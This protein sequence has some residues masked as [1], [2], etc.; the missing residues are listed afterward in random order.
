MTRCAFAVLCTLAAASPALAQPA[1]VILIRHGEKP[2][3]DDPAVKARPEL[4]NELSPKGHQRAWALVPYV[5]G[6]FDPPVAVYAQHPK[7]S[8][9]EPDGTPDSSIRP[10]QTVQKL[11]EA[12]KIPAALTDPPQLPGAPRDKFHDMVKEIMTNPAYQ[13]KVVLICWEHGVLPHVAAALIDAADKRQLI[14]AK[15]L[16]GFPDDLTKWAWPGFPGVNPEHVYDRT[17]VITFDYKAKA[18]K[19]ENLPQRL[20]YQDSD[21]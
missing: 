16:T 20:M 7:P 14:D 11:A 6:T 10:A 13:G 19:F 17:W 1:R 9:I 12:L 5:L 3:K 18:A 4:I 15:S 2:A 8:K 21:K